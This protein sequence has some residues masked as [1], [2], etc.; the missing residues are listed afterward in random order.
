MKVSWEKW[1][2]AIPKSSSDP[3]T[4]PTPSAPSNPAVADTPD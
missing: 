2:V 4:V 1:L 3:R